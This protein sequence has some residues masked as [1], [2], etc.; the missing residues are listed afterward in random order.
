MITRTFA[1]YTTNNDDPMSNFKI[2][3]VLEYKGDNEYPE[4]DPDW[5]RISSYVSVHFHQRNERDVIADGVNNI[6]KQNHI[7]LLKE[8]KE[9]EAL[10]HYRTLEEI[11]RD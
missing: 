10:D 7:K 5:C 2:G 1:L 6:L 3:T 4:N 8:E 11:Y 9:Q